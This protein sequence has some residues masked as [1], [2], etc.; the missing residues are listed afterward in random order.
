MSTVQS[1]IYFLKSKE[2]LYIE[3][4]ILEELDKCN[5]PKT[6]LA[7]QEENNKPFQMTL[8]H[9]KLNIYVFKTHLSVTSV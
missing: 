2:L 3:R 9:D 4:N 5:R 1:K 8:K 6:E 7:I